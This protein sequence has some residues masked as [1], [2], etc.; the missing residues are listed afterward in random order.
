M[1]KKWFWIALIGSILLLVIAACSQTTTT[2]VLDE[3]DDAQVEAL[4]VEKCSQCHTTDRVYEADYTEAEW[5]DTIDDMIS[6]GAKVNAE[7]KAV[8]AD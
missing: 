2:P 8:M 4:I 5:A 3:M 1:T 7:E 6:K